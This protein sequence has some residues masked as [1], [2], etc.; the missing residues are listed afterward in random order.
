MNK[1]HEGNKFLHAS[2]VKVKAS[3]GA[4]EVLVYAVLQNA[5]HPT[6]LRAVQQPH[7]M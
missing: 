4:S 2:P 6:R 1:L 7:L 5:G 3:P